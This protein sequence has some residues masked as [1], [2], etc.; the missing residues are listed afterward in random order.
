VGRLTNSE[1]N[2]GCLF[3]ADPEKAFDRQAVFWSPEA[4]STVFSLREAAAP[5]DIG[6]YD[7]DWSML[8]NGEFRHG[9]DGWHAIV[10]LAGAIHRLYYR[11][12]PQ[13]VRRFPSNCRSI[14]I[15]TYVSKR[16]IDFGPQSKAAVLVRPLLRSLPIDAV[17]LY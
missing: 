16:Q 9:P 17:V 8:G 4:L 2:G 11:E 14:P 10:P 5:S 6:Q 3:A 13:G 7:L 1:K 12:Y 15:S